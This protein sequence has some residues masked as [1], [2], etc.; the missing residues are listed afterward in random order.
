M[1]LADPGPPTLGDRVQLQ[2]VILNLILNAVEAMNDSEPRELSIETRKD[3]GGD[4]FISVSD[5]GSGLDPTKADRLFEPFYSTKPGGMG[6]GLSIC[7]SIIEAHRGTI[8]A[9]P[10]NERGSTFEF[11]IPI[12][13]ESA[14]AAE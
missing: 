5:S 12:E 7:R 9:R 4:A 13:T 11:R 2:Q 6:M 1:K 14:A 8:S 10:N 3:G